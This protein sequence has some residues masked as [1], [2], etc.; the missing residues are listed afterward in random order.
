V[1]RIDDETQRPPAN[2]NVNCVHAS[3]FAAAMD[4]ASARNPMAAN[5]ISGLDANTSAKTP[6]ELD[7]LAELDTEAP[8]D[9]GNNVWPLNAK[10]G[11]V[12]LGGCCGTSTEHIDALARCARTG[13]VN[14]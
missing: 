2:Y 13:S 9:F 7:G 4:V 11:V 12:Y 10:Y 6:E 5:R 1:E 8:A 3:V 14:G